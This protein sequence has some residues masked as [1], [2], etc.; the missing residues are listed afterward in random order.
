MVKKISLNL[1]I[2]EIVHGIF[3]LPF[4]YLLY[5]KTGLIDRFGLVIFFT[6]ILDLD[7][8]VDYFSY[9]GSK[10]N[11][12]KFLSGTCFAQS[13]RAYVFL[14]AWE[15]LIIL[16]ILSY[17]SGWYSLATI[18]TF[19]MIPHIIF[20]SLV[21]KSFVF[22]SIIYRSIKKFTDLK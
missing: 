17:K 18:I 10:F 3:A 16:G 13:K 6:Y 22:Y 20:D 5:K 15:W 11:L 12:Y 21:V 1:L 8:L 4:A 9:Y 2:Q 7:H 14:H 19:A